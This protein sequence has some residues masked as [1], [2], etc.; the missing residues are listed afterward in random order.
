MKTF[1][2]FQQTYLFATRTV[3]RSRHQ[4]HHEQPQ[5][6]NL[7]AVRSR[8]II[9]RSQNIPSCHLWKWFLKNLN[10]RLWEFREAPKVVGAVFP[11][12]PVG[13]VGLLF[14]LAQNL[15]NFRD[16]ALRG[17][18]SKKNICKTPHSELL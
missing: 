6:S 17:L 2:E 10:T 15:F 3:D 7:A 1:V 14:I 13:R 9:L 11:N 18:N 16:C 4:S 12:F 8:V 5:S